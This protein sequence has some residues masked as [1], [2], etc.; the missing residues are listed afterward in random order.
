[1]KK[2]LETTLWCLWPQIFTKK[3]YLK[4]KKRMNNLNF[5]LKF[6]LNFNHKLMYKSKP[7]NQQILSKTKQTTL[8]FTSM[9]S[10][11]SQSK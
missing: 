7:N 6:R 8:N 3:L 10:R 11:L 1:M 4:R 9:I 2:E 5:N